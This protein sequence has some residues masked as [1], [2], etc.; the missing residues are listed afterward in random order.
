METKLIAAEIAT[1]AGVAVI[2]T[3]SKKPETIFDI[4]QYNAKSTLSLQEPVQLAPGEN[5]PTSP[6]L[7]RAAAIRGFITP[8]PS[9]T[10]TPIRPPHTLFKPSLTPM[11]DMKSWTSHTLFPAGSVIIDAGAHNVLSRRES[12]GRLLAAGVLDVEGKFASGQAVRIVVRRK[13]AM[14]VTILSSSS[15][16]TAVAYAFEEDADGNTTPGGT[17]PTSLPSTPILHPSCSLSSSISSIDYLSRSASL[18]S[19]SEVA[20][21][22]ATVT[23]S[24]TVTIPVSVAGA[25]TVSSEVNDAESPNSLAVNEQESEWESV[26]V[27]RGLANYNSVDI[28]KVKG[29]KR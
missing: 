8:T 22:V 1:G 24:A 14:D 21:K 13:K 2:I 3:S 4:I 19:F 29:V 16:T 10:S 17:S 28:L 11:R 5:A 27:G 20:N 18:N 25:S 15:T 6:L 7:D 12:G 23:T 26:E 9:G